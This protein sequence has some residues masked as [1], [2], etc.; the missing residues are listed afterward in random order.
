MMKDRQEKGT[1][2]N[3]TK[4]LLIILMFIIMNLTN[5][6][7]TLAIL[8]VVWWLS[9]LIRYGFNPYGLGDKEGKDIEEIKWCLFGVFVFLVLVLLDCVIY[10]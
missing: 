4:N 7:G 8:I 6:L 1:Q 10:I 3:R 2:E 5:L 9:I